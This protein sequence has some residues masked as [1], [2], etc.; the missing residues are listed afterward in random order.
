MNFYNAN[1]V[2][3]IEDHL[4]EKMPDAF[5]KLDVATK[6]T[7]NLAVGSKHKLSNTDLL[8]VTIAVAFLK[9]TKVVDK[10]KRQKNPV[11]KKVPLAMLTSE[12]RRRGASTA[13]GRTSRRPPKGYVLSVQRL[14]PK[15]ASGTSTPRPSARRRRTA[16][17][18]RD[19]KT[20]LAEI[21]MIHIQRREYHIGG[22]V[23]F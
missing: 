7:I 13:T 10:T 11:V 18:D 14:R 20:V 8:N 12:P 5:K 4:F 2:K 15:S 1:S 19:G 6:E 3:V 16:R 17:N 23:E 21:G 22:P 9:A